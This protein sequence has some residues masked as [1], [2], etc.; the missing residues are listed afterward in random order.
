MLERGDRIEIIST[1]VPLETLVNVNGVN[2]A[3]QVSG[4][5]IDMDPLSTKITLVCTE[6]MPVL[7]TGYLVPEADMKAFDAWRA[8]KG[9][10]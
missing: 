1:G 2:I 10:R 7:V 4:V 6:F 8:E 9:L 3:N 5:R